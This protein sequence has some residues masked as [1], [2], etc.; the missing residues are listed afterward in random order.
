MVIGKTLVV[1]SALLAVSTLSNSLDSLSDVPVFAPATDA[2]NVALVSN[3]ATAASAAKPIAGP[4]RFGRARDGLFYVVATVN[5][6]RVK[7]VLDTGATLVVLTPEDARRI[8]VSGTESGRA[9]S[10]ETA[11]GRSSIRRVTLDHIK[12]AGY[13]VDDVD[14]AIVPTGLK[15]SLL[16]QNLLSQLGPITLS[17]NEAELR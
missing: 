15:T 17:A 11:G 3:V 7:F 14:A 12:V 2:A 13:S 1:G 5:G 9:A 4:T 8:G 16:G 6:A 10:M